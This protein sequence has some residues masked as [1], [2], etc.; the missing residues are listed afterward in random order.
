[1]TTAITYY[2][3]PIEVLEIDGNRIEFCQWGSGF[4]L[5]SVN[6]LKPEALN[7]DQF[8]YCFEAV[9]QHI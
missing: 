9:H 7:N 8:S 4:R 3:R 2:G 5:V 1:M 6:R